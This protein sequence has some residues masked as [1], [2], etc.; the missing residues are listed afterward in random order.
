MNVYLLV[1]RA[2]VNYTGTAATAAAWKA[3][4]EELGPNL[5]DPGNAVFDRTAV[6]PTGSALPL[7]GYTIVTAESVDAAIALAE[8]CPIL[9]AGGGV[10]VGTLTAVPGR[11]HPARTF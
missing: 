10:E 1:H 5:V 7:G 2:P 4:F 9:A 11:Q 8:S 3:W 6:G